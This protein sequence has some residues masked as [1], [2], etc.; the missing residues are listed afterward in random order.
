MVWLQDSI[1]KRLH[2]HTFSNMFSNKI[3][4]AHRAQILS[5]FGPKVSAWLI[6]R[7]VFPTFWLFS[8]IFFTSLQTQFGL[9]RHSIT[10]IP[11]CVCTHPIDLMVIHLL[12]CVHGNMHTK[13]HDAICDTFAAITWDVDFHVRQELHALSLTTFNSSS[14]QV[15]IVLTKDGICTLIDIV[16]ANP[17]RTNLFPWSCA[18]QRF[19][20]FDAT[21]AKEKSYHNQ[22]PT[23]QFLP[24]SIEVFECLHKQVNVF[25][26]NCANAIWSLKGQRALLFL[27]WF[28]FFGENLNHITKDAN[29]F[30]LKSGS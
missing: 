10:D 5:C 2:H 20:A 30:H 4:E 8:P 25:L 11:L 23:D 3:F 15:D 26:H 17:T 18:T 6:V 29:I 12:H 14:Q 7:L 16:I 24:L 22:H 21:Q 9:P 27:P 19:V 1:L 13:I 28:I